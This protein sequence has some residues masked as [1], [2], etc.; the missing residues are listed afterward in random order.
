MGN[1][2]LNSINQS[3]DVNIISQCSLNIDDINIQADITYPKELSKEANVYYN[4][5]GYEFDS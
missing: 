3:S 2:E 1:S 4:Q 5:Q